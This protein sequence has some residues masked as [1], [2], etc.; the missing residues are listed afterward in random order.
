VKHAGV[1]WLREEDVFMATLGQELHRLRSLKGWTL[2]DVEEKTGKKISDSYLYALES[3]QIETP[4]PR[5]LHELSLVYDASYPGLMKLAGF[6][7][8]SSGPE[9]SATSASVA[10]D[11]LNLTEEERN[12]LM[13]FLEFLRRKKK[14]C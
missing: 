2:R 6:V 4:S 10:F 11:S 13:D 9:A 12:E 5:V 7:V 8:P 1:R 3:G 14:K